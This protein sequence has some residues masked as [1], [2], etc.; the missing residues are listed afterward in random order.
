MKL[1]VVPART[2]AQ[3][4]REG[5]RLFFKQ[6]LAF[7]GL[8]FVFMAFGQLASYVPVAGDFVAL[9]VVPAFTIC[10][11]AASR[12]GTCARVAALLLA[13]NS[14]QLSSPAFFGAWRSTMM[15]ARQAGRSAPSISG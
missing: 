2:G 7:A 15:W 11:M 1:R 8:F 14:S 4:V 13:K 10:M 12:T 6:P 3:W 5:L 9:L